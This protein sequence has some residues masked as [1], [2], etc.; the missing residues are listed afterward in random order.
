[1]NNVERHDKIVHDLRK[2]LISIG[3]GTFVIGA[4][5][6]DIAY[7]LTGINRTAL[8]IGGLGVVLLTGSGLFFL[9]TTLLPKVPVTWL[10]STKGTRASTQPN[11]SHSADGD[12]L[13]TIYE[14]EVR[15]EN[16]AAD[17]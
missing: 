9:L 14:E 12:D 13:E 15:E 16:A 1:M 3:L 4:V 7:L 17:E 5:V 10:S 6:F 8:Q 2:R 11:S